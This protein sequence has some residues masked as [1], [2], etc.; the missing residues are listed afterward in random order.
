MVEDI[1]QGKPVA[2]RGEEGRSVVTTA[3][4]EVQDIILDLL[5]LRLIAVGYIDLNALRHGLATA[6]GRVGEGFDTSLL[7]GRTADV[8]GRN[9]G[10]GRYVTLHERRH[11]LRLCCLSHERCG[12]AEHHEDRKKEMFH[13]FG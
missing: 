11:V 12:H 9:R 3:M 7:T 13:C 2:G 8:L 1:A 10:D 4:H 5:V 6:M